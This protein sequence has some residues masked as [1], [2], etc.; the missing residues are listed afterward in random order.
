[1][2]TSSRL[3]DEK[4][5]GFKRDKHGVWWHEFKDGRRIR[6]K[7][8]PCKCCGSEF[9]S[10]RP[11]KYCSW[12]CEHSKYSHAIKTRVCAGCQREFIVTSNHKEQRYCSRECGLKATHV[13]HKPTTIRCDVAEDLV[14]SDNPRY[15]QD[16]E[17]Q[18]WYSPGGNKEHGRTRA[19]ILTCER[20]GKRFLTNHN[21]RRRARFC[22]RQCGGKGRRREGL[23][24]SA[25]SNWQGGRKI[26]RGYVV[27]WAPD[28]PTRVGKAKPYV[29]EHRLVME[30]RIGRVLETHENVHHINGQRDDN[31]DENLEL[32][33]TWQPC[34]QRVEDKMK[35]VWEMVG[36][37]EHLYPRPK[38]A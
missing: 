6:G 35:W 7:Y 26:E 2:N 33:S 27:V 14:N 29:F 23:K 31:R 15:S 38:P 8:I 22:T 34:G 10:W 3:Q 20:C 18:W 32:W 5:R 36:L 37:Y 9:I 16:D 24:G 13:S 25:A 28:H 11:A 19:S 17:G 30:K 1:M 12:K 4:A 21:H